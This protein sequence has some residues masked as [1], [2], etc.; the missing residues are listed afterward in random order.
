[1]LILIFLQP[2]MVWL[3]ITS[4]YYN[5]AWRLLW[6]DHGGSPHMR[7]ATYNY[8]KREVLQLWFE[9]VGMHGG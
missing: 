6:V 8:G 7:K 2:S 1:M 4:H 9:A 5:H 3:R